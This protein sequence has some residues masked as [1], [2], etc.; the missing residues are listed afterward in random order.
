M[1]DPIRKLFESAS[2]PAEHRSARQA[3]AEAT[4]AAM[5][6][7]QRQM[8][9]RCGAAVDRLDEEAFERLFEEEQAKVDVFREPLMAAAERDMWPRE[10]YFGGI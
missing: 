2:Q 9:E 3:W 6:A 4:V 10:L 7:A 5:F 1:N 8:D